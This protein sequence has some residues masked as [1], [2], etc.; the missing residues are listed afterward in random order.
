MSILIKNGR[1]W[2]GERFFFS[3]IL[4]DGKK[5]AEIGENINYPADF[6]FDAKGKTVS[7]GLVDSHVHI[8]GISSDEWGVNAELSCIPF[9]VTVAVDAGG[10]LGSKE[11]L[12]FF[13]IKSLVFVCSNIKDNRAELSKI[14]EIFEKYA[15]KAVGIKTYFDIETASVRNIEPLLQIIN[16]AEK[17]G[18]PIMV[19]SSN[20]PIPMSELLQALRKGDI[21]THAYH[22]G[23]NNIIEDN[24]E[25][26]FEAKKRG[27]VID[28]GFAGHVHTD[29]GI[30]ENAVRCGALPDTISTDITKLSAY[31]RGGRYGMTM[32]MSMAKTVG[33]SE[34]EIFR[35]V[36]SSPAAV[37][38]KQAE[39]GHIKVGRCADIAVFDFDGE[40]FSLT[41]KFGN[42]LSSD[43]SYRC[44]LTVAGGDVAYRA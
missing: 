13:T 16:Y 34:E 22:G 6:V 18:V 33:M 7:P 40:G 39:W 25:C 4:T 24:F 10:G 8:R 29:F 23:K 37:F 30:F 38:G 14:D 11:L 1:V 27:V 12:D 3:D 19:H 15:E 35:A 26:I 17:R 32:C 20:P 9:G 21:L 42:T 41:D 31:K 28:T 2:D 36:T 5:I 43:K 44:V